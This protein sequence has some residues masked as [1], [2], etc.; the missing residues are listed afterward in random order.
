MLSLIDSPEIKDEI[1]GKIIASYAHPFFWAPFT[2]F[3][4]GSD[5]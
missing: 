3:G 2:I 4:E 5:N 1:S